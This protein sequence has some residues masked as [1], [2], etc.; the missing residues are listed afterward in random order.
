VAA[1]TCG[2]LGD[3]HI[4]NAG[5]LDIGAKS[6]IVAAGVV[7]LTVGADVA[8]NVAG[9]APKVQAIIAPVTTSCPIQISLFKLSNQISTKIF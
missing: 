2:L 6:I 7:A 1:A 3:E 8:L 4:P 9:A 5:I